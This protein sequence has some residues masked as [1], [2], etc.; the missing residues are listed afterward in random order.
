MTGA[1]I[2]QDKARQAGV[3]ELDR[4]T[5]GPLTPEQETAR[6][7]RTMDLLLVWFHR[8]L[9]RE[10]EAV[11]DMAQRLVDAATEAVRRRDQVQPPSSGAA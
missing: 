8:M 7:A 10:P 2:A 9:E 5:V 11:L 1:A 4:P 3:T 6:N